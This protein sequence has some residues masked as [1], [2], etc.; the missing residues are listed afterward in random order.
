VEKSFGEYLKTLR[1]EYGYTLLELGEEIG[2]SD[3]Y[4]SQIEKGRKKNPPTIHLLRDLSLALD[5]P[6]SNMLE[7]AGYKELAAGQRLLETVGGYGDDS[8]QSKASGGRNKENLDPNLVLIKQN[9]ESYLT[10]ESRYNLNHTFTQKVTDF[11]NRFLMTFRVYLD[12][13]IVAY[14]IWEEFSDKYRCSEIEDLEKFKQAFLNMKLKES[15]EEL[16]KLIQEFSDELIIDLSKV[17]EK[18]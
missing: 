4:L 13:I 3:A 14:G 12:D 16:L 2:Y 11:L 17:I 9:I 7:V 8:N 1:M 5:E 10:L 15:K 6:Y 18:Q